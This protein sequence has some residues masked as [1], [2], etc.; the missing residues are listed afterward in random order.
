[1]VKGVMVKGLN[2]LVKGKTAT[3]S[4]A[5]MISAYPLPHNVALTHLRYIAVEN[6]VRK[7]GFAC[8]K[9]F[10]LFSKC[11][12]PYMVLNINIKFTLKCCLQFISIWTTLKYNGIHLVMGLRHIITRRVLYIICWSPGDYFILNN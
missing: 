2:I 5:Q 11:F 12:L 3:Q 8:N 7:G 9:Q 10:L 1:M 6:I 4:I